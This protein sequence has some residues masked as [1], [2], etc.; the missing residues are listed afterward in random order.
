MLY[1]YQDENTEMNPQSPYAVAKLAA[2]KM[3]QL[4]RNAYGMFCCCG[5]LMNHESPRRGEEF[6]TKK[7]SKYVGRVYKE[8]KKMGLLQMSNE[9]KTSIIT[10]KIGKLQLGNLS[11]SRDWGHSRDYMLAAWQMLQQDI[12]DDYVIC[13]EE[14]HTVE[15]F[16]KLAFSEIGV[17]NYMDF[18]NIN[19]KYMR[20]AEVLFLRGRCTKAK[21]KLK[22]KA[23]I[24]F[25]DLVKDMVIYDCK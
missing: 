22:W 16:L 21:E 4:Y 8:I 19:S 15:E 9:E 17:N 20:P 6:V 7:I 14:T 2:H 24:T 10:N 1:N 11:A 12:P 23:N 3:T 25:R 18:V 5:I 13:T